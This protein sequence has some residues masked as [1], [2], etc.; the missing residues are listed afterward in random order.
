MTAGDVAT[1]PTLD[2]L[3]ALA[4]SSPWLW[5]TLRFTLQIKGRETYG[6][7][8]LRAWVSRPHGLRVEDVDGRLIQAG[9]LPRPDEGMTELTEG[10]T[11]RPDGLVARRPEDWQ[12]PFRYDDPMFSNYRWVAM[13]QPFEL[14]DGVERDD[15]GRQYGRWSPTFS[16]IEVADGPRAV[17]HHGRSAWEA[18]VVTTPAY[19]ARCSCCPLLGGDQAAQ[20]LAAEGWAHAS[21][22]RPTSWRVR[23]D[24]GTGVLVRLREL[25]ATGAGGW[26]MHIEAADEPMPRSLFGPDRL[27]GRSSATVVSSRP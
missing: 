26:T 22:G 10:P 15:D 14:A 1:T 6:T 7:D 12:G 17:D 20:N 2:D 16:P 27:G 3:R 13:L 18:E 9:W 25:G 19:A 8:R 11:L 21:V 4:R 5:R 23:L 24:R